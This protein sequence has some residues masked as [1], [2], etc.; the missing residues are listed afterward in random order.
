MT[1]CAT[2]SSAVFDG[3]RQGC[4]RLSEAPIGRSPRKLS[5]SAAKEA[6]C[7]SPL[8]PCRS[9]CGSCQHGSPCPI[10]PVSFLW[11]I[12]HQNPSLSHSMLPY[13]Q[14]A[15]SAPSFFIVSMLQRR[16]VVRRMVRCKLAV[17]QGTPTLS[18]SAF[19]VREDDRRPQNSEESA[20]NRVLLSFC[21]RLRR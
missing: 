1:C 19:A 7:T 16:S 5:S 13:P 12:G 10:P 3:Y 20:V 8:Q 11:M 9:N 4:L 6:S 15:P 2:T 14:E 17:C 18:S 21:P